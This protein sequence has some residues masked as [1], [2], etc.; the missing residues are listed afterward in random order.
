MDIWLVKQAFIVT[1]DIFGKHFSL[2]L[3]CVSNF[4][5]I[6][7]DGTFLKRKENCP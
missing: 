5:L 2:R 3:T 6:G 4:G 7:G 1:V